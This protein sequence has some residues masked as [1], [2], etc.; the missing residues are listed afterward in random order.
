M[1]AAH[2]P[3]YVFY[4]IHLVD[5][6]YDKSAVGVLWSLGVFAEIGVFISMPRLLRA[7]SP[8]VILMA[9][10]VLGVL[11]FLLIGWGA[12]YVGLMFLAQVMHG[13][14]FGA[15]HA[16]AVA[17]LNHWFPPRQQ[18]RVQA[19]YGS[20]SFGA[21]GMIGNFASG[22]AWESL[23]PALTFTLGATFAAAGLLLTW[24]GMSSTRGDSR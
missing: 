22:A 10:F 3:F 17:A 12:D 18:G 16:A 13:A 11:R 7:W 23:G 4:S 5:H 15:F 8:R 6:G 2:G 14:T 9:S 19:L 20:V 21:G 24:F 1:S